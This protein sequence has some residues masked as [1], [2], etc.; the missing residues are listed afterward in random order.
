[1]AS[2]MLP[3]VS[4]AGSVLV[5]HVKDVLILGETIHILVPL[6]PSYPS[7]K[8][9]FKRTYIQSPSNQQGY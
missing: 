3:Q 5:A 1:M 2:K 8:L 6:A 7:R 4:A 9:A